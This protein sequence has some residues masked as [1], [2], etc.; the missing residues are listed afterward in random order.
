[1]NYSTGELAF[2]LIVAGLLAHPGTRLAGHSGARSD[3]ALVAAAAARRARAVVRAVLRGDGVAFHRTAAARTAAVP[4]RRGRR[5]DGAGGAAVHDRRDPRHCLLV[6]AAVR[7]PRV[8][9]DPRCRWAGLDGGPPVAGAAV[10][11]VVVK[12][13]RRHRAVRAGAV[14]HRMVA[15]EGARPGARPRLC[16]QA[17]VGADGAVHLRLGHR[18]AVRCA[19]L[20]QLARPGRIAHAAAVGL[21]PLRDVGG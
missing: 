4:D 7:R 11:N 9:V 15:A 21:G 2:I 13:Q 14:A 10:A 16:A 8:G 6:V 1:M 17:V 19:Y 3:V 12:R 18:A 5:A 20:G